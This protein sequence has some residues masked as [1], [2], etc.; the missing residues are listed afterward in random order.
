[1]KGETTIAE[2]FEEAGASGPAD[3][4]RKIREYQYEL[5]EGI[6]NKIKALENKRSEYKLKLAEMRNLKEALDARG[7]E[8]LVIIEK[9]KGY[10]AE[11]FVMKLPKGT[12]YSGMDYI[13][14]PGQDPSKGRPKSF[15]DFPIVE[16]KIFCEPGRELDDSVCFKD[17]DKYQAEVIDHALRMKKKYDAALSF[18]DEEWF[19]ERYRNLYQ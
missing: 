11:V 18:E 2:E 5:G 8:H 17:I 1:M 15:R 13:Y 14:L 19:Y 9:Q 6:D 4:D 3:L 16:S 12:K 7:Y 10:P